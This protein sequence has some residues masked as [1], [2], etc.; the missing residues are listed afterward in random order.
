MPAQVDDLDG[1]QAE[2]PG[3]YASTSCA[4]LIFVRSAGPNLAVRG[5][6]RNDPRPLLDINRRRPR[7]PQEVI[8]RGRILVLQYSRAIL[9]QS[10]GRYPRDQR[11]RKREAL[12][13]SRIIL[14]SP[15]IVIVVTHFP[16]RRHHL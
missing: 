9:K 6:R 12:V 16:Q 2:T 10:V 4:K 1:D 5:Q 14:G 13:E 3:G 7:G 8:D 11:A 15:S